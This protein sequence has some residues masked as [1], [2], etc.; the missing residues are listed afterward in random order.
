MSYQNQKPTSP[1][2][3]A[4]N[5]LPVLLL[6]EGTLITFGWVRCFADFNETLQKARKS[7]KKVVCVSRA[8]AALFEEP[9]MNSPV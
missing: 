2:P 7:S 8:V 9:L 4:Y 1:I 3:I 6:P 5:M